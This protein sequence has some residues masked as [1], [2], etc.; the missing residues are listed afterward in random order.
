MDIASEGLSC[1]DWRGE[2]MQSFE[3]LKR[4]G[5]TVS[6]AL[7]LGLSLGLNVYLGTETRH[8]SLPFPVS[9]TIKVNTDLPSPLPVLDE[10]GNTTQIVFDDSRPT[11]LYVLSPACGWCKR[12]E[13]NIKALVSK[14]GSR[15]RFVGLSVV[16]AGL[17]DYATRGH[18][19]FPVYAVQSQKQAAK[20]GL[21]GTP[22]TLVVGPGAKVE[23][24]WMGAYMGDNQNQVEQFFGTKLPGLQEVA[25]VA[26]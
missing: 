17:K 18:A 25:A 15:F 10:D 4:N 19:P 24:A 5:G 13:A 14:A 6:L 2:A 8:G 23:K 26:H 12:N 3:W 22:E 1:Q 11:V 20:L 16:S 9:E 21:T 7:V